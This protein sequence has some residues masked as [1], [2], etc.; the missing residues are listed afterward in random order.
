MCGQSYRGTICAFFHFAALHYGE[1]Q[2]AESSNDFTH[3]MKVCLKELRESFNCLKLI[4]RKKW[5]DEE[6]VNALV[7]ENN[8]LIAIFV[9][10][11]KTVVQ[12]KRMAG[13]M[14]REAK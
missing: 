1:A 11:L 10:S 8:E 3:K 14:R 4:R 6:K 9:A 7:A 5:C 2:A 13:H 12:N